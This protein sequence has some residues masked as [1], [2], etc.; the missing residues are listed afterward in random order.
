MHTQAQIHGT[1]PLVP[2][3]GVN[4][5]PLALPVTCRQYPTPAME[6]DPKFHPAPPSL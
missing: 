5:C 4:T 6:P 2:S 1:D 3:P